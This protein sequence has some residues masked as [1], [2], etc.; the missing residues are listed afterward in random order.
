MSIAS[1]GPATLEK[2]KPRFPN[3][4]RRDDIIEPEINFTRTFTQFR[5]TFNS[6]ADIAGATPSGNYSHLRNSFHTLLEIDDIEGTR[7]RVTEKMHL[8]KRRVNPLEPHYP[9]PSAITEPEPPPKFLRDSMS[10]QDIDGAQVKN[11]TLSTIRDTM[12]TIDID[13]AQA[14]WRP[15]HRYVYL[16]HAD[17]F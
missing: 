12:S 14:S 10:V 15:I 16:L 17:I 4:I 3:G 11:R 2:P 1:L 13:G 6:T 8:T 7:A 5:S 9:L